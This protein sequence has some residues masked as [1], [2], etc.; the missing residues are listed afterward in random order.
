MITRVM[1]TEKRVDDISR[2][3]VRR[4]LRAMAEQ[5]PDVSALAITI[6]QLPDEDL[7]DWIL[8]HAK[9]ERG[10]KW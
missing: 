5:H 7:D 3:R 9:E 4:N 10:S 8:K 6:C 2:A 1:L